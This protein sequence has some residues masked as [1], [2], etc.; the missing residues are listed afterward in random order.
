MRLLLVE[1]KE[2]FRRLLVKAL[3]GSAWEVTA[4]GDPL[5]A[6]RALDAAPFD[7]L[8]TDLRLPSLSGLDLLKA[9]KRAQPA[10]RAVVMSAFGETKDVVEAIRWGADDFLAKPFD[11]DAF[12]AVLERLRALGEAPPPDPR[13]PWIAHSPAVLALDR[14]LARAAESAVPVLFHGEPGAGKSRAARRLHTL[15][16]PQ[17]PFL[18]LPAA[19]LVPASLDL[20]LLHGGSVFLAGLEQLG[21]ARPLAAA[22]DSEAGSRVRW[23]GA[24][25]DPDALAEA[26][27]LRLGVLTL[28]VP[29][30]RERREDIL[31]LFRAFLEMQAR[32][33]GRAVPFVEPKVERELLARQWPGNLRQMTWS[34]AQALGASPGSVLAD[35]PP[36]SARRA[37]SLVLPDPGP[38]TLEAMLQAVGRSAEG[39]L[40]RR[41]L[42]GRREDPAGVAR[43]LGL[44]PRAFARALKD[45]AI[46]L[47]DE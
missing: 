23:M 17:A 2:S 41:A 35:L 25:S 42:E 13:E 40:L 26:V 5:E 1:D 47:E 15:R 39:V 7:V 12:S 43:D 31:P 24:C 37:A 32:R 36:D 9:A 27:R 20:A 8:V 4:L 3:E 30:L 45:H 29:P 44:S 19:S 46:P 33:E 21:D 34:V 10:L 16:H 18:A 14:A 28:R 22:M 6:K 11:L 38:G